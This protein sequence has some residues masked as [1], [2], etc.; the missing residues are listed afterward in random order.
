MKL[1]HQGNVR[2]ARGTREHRGTPRTKR[3]L[4]STSKELPT[5]LP[6]IRARVFRLKVLPFLHP[7]T[8]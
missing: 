7:S 8:D 3:N 5:V 2:R 1:S 4:G 6:R